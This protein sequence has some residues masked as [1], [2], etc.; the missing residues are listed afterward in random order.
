MIMVF[1]LLMIIAFAVVTTAL[2]RLKDLIPYL[3]SI[4]LLAFLNPVVNGYLAHLLNLLDKQ[5]FFLLFEFVFLSAAIL[6]WARNG[7]PALWPD[8]AE[9]R[10]N[11]N[12]KSL[13]MNPDLTLL[14]IVVLAA[15]GVQVFLILTVA[16]NNND[17]LA[18]HVPRVLFWLQHGNF[19]PW[20]TLRLPQIFYPINAQLPL[21]WTVLFS[22]SW[23]YLGFPQ[24]FSQIVAALAIAGIAGFMGIKKNGQVFA[25]L[26]FLTYPIIAAQ[27]T[28]AQN[29]LVIGTLTAICLYFFFLFLKEPKNIH[30]ILSGMAL[31]LAAGTKPTS[32]FLCSWHV[33]SLGV[34][35][36]LQTSEFQTI[37]ALDRCFSSYLHLIRCV[38][39]SPELA[40]LWQS[41]GSRCHCR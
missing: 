32:Y 5:W 26:I 30:L 15:M 9:S 10:Q 29:D 24:F 25:G 2:F 35:G 36:P 38:D 7:K 6:L 33:H 31:A 3:L 27:S 40:H 16:P 11:F 39:Q 13:L 34:G 21:L 20:E 17:S 23:N 41:V 4:Y 28:T 1:S 12:V 37:S 19:L 22:H 14:G 8:S 18:M